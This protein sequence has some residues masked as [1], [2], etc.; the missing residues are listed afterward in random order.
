MAA[1]NG[2]RQRTEGD[3][4]PFLRLPGGDRR[5]AG[6]NMRSC[7][8]GFRTLLSRMARANC[9]KTCAIIG[10]GRLLANRKEQ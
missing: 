2:D 1:P 8:P 9:R 5:A 7:K 6:P 4:E 3:V 10:L